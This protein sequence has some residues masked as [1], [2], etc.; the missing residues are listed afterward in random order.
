MVNSFE[1]RMNLL[2]EITLLRN[3]ISQL[4]SIDKLLG[5]NSSEKKELHVAL[6]ELDKHTSSYSEFAKSSHLFDQEQHHSRFVASMESRHERI[7][8]ELEAVHHKEITT[9]KAKHQDE[10]SNL[11]KTHTTTVTDLQDSHALEISQLKHKHSEEVESINSSHRKEIE[12]K[13]SRL[14]A[15]RAE[16]KLVERS[17][18]EKDFKFIERIILAT[19]EKINLTLSNWVDVLITQAFSSKIDDL[20]EQIVQFEKKEAVR[21]IKGWGKVVLSFIPGA[22]AVVEVA[23]VVGEVGS[24]AASYI[25]TFFEDDTSKLIEKTAEDVASILS[26]LGI[27]IECIPKQY[28]EAFT[29]S[30]NELTKVYQ[31]AMQSD[32]RDLTKMSNEELRNCINNAEAALN[33]AERIYQTSQEIKIKGLEKASRKVGT[34]L[35]DLNREVYKMKGS[36]KQLPKK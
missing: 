4:I 23:G 26:G 8:A 17:S 31:D 20:Q 32:V 25:S 7:V 16:I 22:G 34:R 27:P 2:F 36:Q 5:L 9:L 35:S 1:N 24:A 29:K 19:Q 6:K 10:L 14:A 21:R 3:K 12:T 30:L 15:A 18:K 11:E 28:I 33:T 13:N